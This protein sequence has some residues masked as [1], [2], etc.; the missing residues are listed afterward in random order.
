MEKGELSIA[1]V[2]SDYVNC[3]QC[4][5]CELR[6]P[7]TLF[8]GDFYRFRTRTVDLVKGVAHWP[9]TRASTSP[10]GSGGTP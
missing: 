3:T 4:G 2:A 6:C 9:S 8:T 7:N 1:D 10:D 5:A